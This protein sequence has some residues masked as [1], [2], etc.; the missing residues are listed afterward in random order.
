MQITDMMTVLN[1][2][3]LEHRLRN[4]RFYL[5]V[6]DDDCWSTPFL[7]Y[8]EQH[9]LLCAET[10]NQLNRKSCVRFA[11][12][13]KFFF[14]LLTFRCGSAWTMNHALMNR[15]KSKFRFVLQQIDTYHL[16]PLM[17]RSNEEKLITIFELFHLANDCAAKEQNM[18]A[19]STE[20]LVLSNQEQRNVAHSLW[21]IYEEKSERC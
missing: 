11:F 21:Q 6:I 7:S 8:T 5:N 10:L 16:C 2:E 13:I 1:V 19:F 15:K 12:R 9:W 18:H 14:S 4:E 17:T 3:L 20:Y